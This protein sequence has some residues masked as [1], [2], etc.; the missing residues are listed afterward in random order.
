MI[1]LFALSDL[2]TPVTRD[3]AK[4]SIYRVLGV[5]GIDTTSWK[6]GAVV[7]TLITAVAIIVSA[8]STLTAGIAASGFLD[9]ATG[10]WL[11]LV[12][13][14]TFGV[15]RISATYASGAVTLV[16]AGGGIYAL[17]PED[18]IVTNPQTGKSYRNVDPIS[19]GA[20][21]TVTIS[22]VAIEQGAASTS[23]PG[24][25]TRLET[26][27]TGVSCSNLL[28]VVGQDAE[29]DPDL[30]VRCREKLGSLS[31]NGPWDAYAYFARTATRLDGS[32]IGVTRVRVTRDGFGNVAVFVGTPTGSVNGTMTDTSTDLGA[33]HDRLQKKATPL[34]VTESTWP[35]IVHAVPLSYTVYLYNTSGLSEQAIK[36]AIAAKLTSYLSTQPIGGNIV[37]TQGWLY[38]D[39]LRSAIASVRPEIFHVVL[40]TPTSDVELSAAEVPVLGVISGTVVQIAPKEGTL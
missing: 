21:A 32:S 24:A 3:D 1:A 26:T 13:K 23:S 12:A 7:R 5:T 17:D 38:A 22:I 19:L 6:P 28:A 11:D 40:A 16:N 37:G 20:F 15:D 10:S 27:L 25:I 30:R 18:L 4:A 31:P 2:V 34:C 36:D 29:S 9:F 39:A 33:I 8:F 14:Y 35:T